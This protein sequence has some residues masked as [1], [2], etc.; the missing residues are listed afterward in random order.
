MW[1]TS[2]TN[3]TFERKAR[4][5]QDGV[6]RSTPFVQRLVENKYSCAECG[7]LSA[8]F[9]AHKGTWCDLKRKG[10]EIAMRAKP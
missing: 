8:Q 9:G 2:C 7:P 1:S 3:I 10:V 5:V 4:D 6:L